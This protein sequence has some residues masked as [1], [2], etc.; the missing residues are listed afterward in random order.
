MIVTMLAQFFAPLKLALENRASAMVLL[1]DLGWT[2]DETFELDA[3]APIAPVLTELQQLVAAADTY[4]PD[5]PDVGAIIENSVQLGQQI[6]TAVSALQTMADNGGPVAL[7]APLDSGA[8]WRDFALDLPEY[9]VLTYLRTYQRPVHAL[10]DFGGAIVLEPRADASRPPRETLDWDAMGRLFT[11]PAG[12]IQDTYNWGSALEH[13]RLTEKLRGLFEAVGIGMRYYLPPD[14]LAQQRFGGQ[15][16]ARLYALGGPL[17]QSALNASTSQIDSTDPTAT[18][19]EISAQIGI[20]L[21]GLLLPVPPVGQTGDPT[22]LLLTFQALGNVDIPITLGNGW[23]VNIDLQVDASGAIGA[24]LQPTGLSLVSG[25]PTGS[26]SANLI[27]APATP[28]PLLGNTTGSRLS[29]GGLNFGAGISTMGGTPDVW[30]DLALSDLAVIIAPGE[31]DG[32]LSNILGDVE[33]A[34]PLS[35]G[36]R[37]SKRDGL[38]MTGGAGISFTLPINRKIGPLE[39]F[40]LDVDLRASTSGAALTTG[41]AGS[42]SIGPFVA[43]VDGIGFKIEVG[44]KPRGQQGNGGAVDIKVGFKPPV[45]LG[46]SVEVPGVKGGGYL[47]INP[48]E[49]RYFGILDLNVFGLQ[50]TAIGLISTRLPDGSDGWSM[51]LSISII[52]PGGIPL[53]FGFKLAGVGGLVG[54]NRGLDIEAL[55]DGV[56]TGAL[57]AI[58]FPE[59]AV[60]NAPMILNAIESIFPAQ[61]GQ[62]VFGPV[63]RI[64]W[65]PKSLVTIDL[66]VVIQLPDPVTISLLGSIGIKIGKDDVTIIDIQVDVVGTLWPSEGRLSIDSS[67]RRG[68]IAML[69]L[70][71]DMAVRLDFGA[72]TPNFLVANGGFHPQFEQPEGFPT[73]ARLALNIFDE[74]NLRVG[75]EAYL[76]VTS[77]SV[78]FGVAAYFWAKAIGL[79]ADGRFEFDTLIYLRPF[80]LMASIG[81]QVTIKAGSTEIL[82]ITLRGTLNG[83]QPWVVTGYAEFK[84]LG[85][86]KKFRVEATLGRAVSEGPQ[87]VAEIFDT[88][89]EAL[90]DPA[91]WRSGDVPELITSALSLALPEDGDLLHPAGSI[92]VSQGIAPL[93]VRL[94]VFGTSRLADGEDYLELTGGHVA[95]N[96]ATTSPVDDWFAPA[97]F[98]EMEEEDRVSAPSFEQLQGGARLTTAA[99]DFGPDRPAAPGYESILIDP[100]VEAEWPKPDDTNAP[101]L[102]AR[103][104]GFAFGLDILTILPLDGSLLKKTAPQPTFEV[105]A[106][107]YVVRDPNGQT[108]V[109]TTFT[110]ALSQQRARVASGLKS[111]VLQPTFEIQM[112]GVIS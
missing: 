100:D 32:F 17:L 36:G 40:D 81:F 33:F 39:I 27:A 57:D 74:E 91:A 55:G 35:F 95:G 5:N 97:Q 86:K 70:S 109:P 60:A 68:Q 62:F 98:F 63:F 56:R 29:L 28:F 41:V 46:L 110:A 58:L 25:T 85:I 1:K 12:Q 84:V 49:G 72:S 88:V 108:S 77:N 23:S 111:P 54:V 48:E 96:I 104:D 102:S 93:G 50:I 106:L 16:P 3:F 8:F 18:A 51:Y 79:T 87:E 61:I 10:I 94:E 101:D 69:N 92:D 7:I 73:L 44:P 65:G 9:L 2:L 42:L 71:G 78:Q 105:K 59:D 112:S 22:G 37:W 75:V 64:E 14:A 80:G 11:D 52:F 31:G 34:I 89:L 45:G 38:S 53:A 103:K 20:A 47:E 19:A 67:I 76:S 26:A 30:L 82:Q 15:P 13:A 43:V 66:G 107:T 4:D 83:P 99:P 6:F 24:D 21:D 90:A